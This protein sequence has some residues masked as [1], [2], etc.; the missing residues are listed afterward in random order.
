MKF[1]L[2]WGKLI[3]TSANGGFLIRSARSTAQRELT[4]SEHCSGPLRKLA[5]KPLT[6][7]SPISVPV[8][9]IK[10]LISFRI[11]PCCII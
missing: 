6:Y 3:S 10:G 7:I 11:K 1:M 8:S 2:Q 9:D 5:C 4:D